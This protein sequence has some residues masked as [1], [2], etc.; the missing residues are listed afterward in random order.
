[1]RLLCFVVAIG[2]LGACGSDEAVPRFELDVS[3]TF[4]STGAAFVG[5]HG[6]DVA[7]ACERAVHSP[8][9]LG[10]CTPFS[11]VVLP[12][13]GSWRCV[14]RFSVEVNGASVAEGGPTERFENS[15]VFEMPSPLAASD[16]AVLV[17][18]GCGTSARVS[19]PTAPLA[20]PTVTRFSYDDHGVHTF[21]WT[22]AEGATSASGYVSGGIS[23]VDCRRAGRGVTHVPYPY[24]QYSSASLA[25]IADEGTVDTPYGPAQLSRIAVAAE[26]PPQEQPSFDLDVLYTNT[27]APD[28]LARVVVHAVV[29]GE[30]CPAV[31]PAIPRVGR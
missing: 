25:A 8:P 21:E 5:V 15:V 31:R 12:S 17:I 20:P 22:G 14:S 19:L 16:A 23:G 2:A 29:R 27:G 3:V 11:D 1:M 28:F 30:G 10:T 4:T 18:E 24:R 13:C 26:V 7:A 6:I 9:A